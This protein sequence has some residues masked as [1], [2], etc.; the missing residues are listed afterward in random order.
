M[1]AFS[2]TDP[3]VIAALCETLTRAGVDGLEIT[4]PDG[5]VRIVVSP[6]RS[7]E[8]S[9]SPTAPAN[10]VGT[11]VVKAPIAG[12]FRPAATDIDGDV[13]EVAG[14]ENLGFIAIG[15]ILVPLVAPQAGLLRRQLAEP[16]TLVGFGTPLFELQKT[17]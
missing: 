5:H 1:S 3:A 9:R 11:A 7:A 8:V 13:H 15:P 17:P 2:L 10:S 16:E 4:G 14:G 12:H 6:L